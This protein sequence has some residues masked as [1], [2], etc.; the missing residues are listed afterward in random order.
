MSPDQERDFLLEESDKLIN[1]IRV[2][3]NKFELR[4]KYVG[5]K[6]ES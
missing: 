5:G 6:N 4:T 2:L 3:I 1:E